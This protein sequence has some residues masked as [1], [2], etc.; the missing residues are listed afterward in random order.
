MVNNQIY[1]DFLIS[2]L[3]L[4]F[5]NT[6]LCY[7]QD[8]NKNKIRITQ[9]SLN[10]AYF[11]IKVCRF[12]CQ[13]QLHLYSSFVCMILFFFWMTSLEINQVLKSLK[14]EKEPVCIEYF[15]TGIC[16]CT[17]FANYV[18][19]FAFSWARYASVL[20]LLHVQYRLKLVTAKYKPFQCNGTCSVYYTIY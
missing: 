13:T 16:K 8:L 7:I 15:L 18:Q 14:N 17:Q 10:L 4:S 2:F 5:K 3:F 20:T 1:N 9:F 19:T 6:I 12:F 11:E